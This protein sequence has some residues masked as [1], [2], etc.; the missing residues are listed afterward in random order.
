MRLITLLL[1]QLHFEPNQVRNVIFNFSIIKAAT[2]KHH[3]SEVQ[4]LI[5]AQRFQSLQ[6]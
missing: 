1:K 4:L 6:Y 5:T 3:R 2:L